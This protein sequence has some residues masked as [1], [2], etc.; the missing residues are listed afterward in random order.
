VPVEDTR[1]ENNLTVQFV[2]HLPASLEG[3]VVAY[4]DPSLR[5]ATAAHHSATHLLHAAL[6]KV[7][8]THV[9]QKG[10][11]VNADYLRFDFSHFAKVTDDEL[12]RVE[13]IVNEKIR[14]NIPVVIREM[15]KDEAIALG[16]M[17]LFGEKYGDRVRVV[18]IDPKYSI[19]LCG[20]THA[21]STGELGFFKVTSEGA[22]AAGVRRIEAVAGIA[23]E[24]YILEQW[25]IVRAVREQVKQ[26]KDIVG[27]VTSIVAENAEIRK[28]LER[29]EA[30]QLAALS[31]ELAGR[32]SMVDGVRFIGEVV[33]V[34][35][36]DALK[37][38]CFDLKPL[39]EGPFVVVLAAAIDGKASVVLMID[40]SLVV[41]K[42]WEAPKL[43]RERV[44][45]LIG[46]GGGGQKTLAT[47][48]I[49]PASRLNA[50]IGAVREAI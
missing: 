30:K 21:G 10:S 2:D 18:I 25:G 49:L 20:G 50:V 36:A 29:L 9:A 4:V 7:L 37:K 46:G 14:E 22:V 5:K 44:A 48:G 35:S 39:L 40:E 43:I 45:P 17:A 6:R 3:P 33:E 15:S 27:A 31:R 19:E 12:A 23:A 1:K 47:A 11:L 41:S 13:A 38:V 16:A 8:G 24:H 26:A 32:V 34:S 42:G 28:R